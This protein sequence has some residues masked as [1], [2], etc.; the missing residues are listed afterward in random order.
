MGGIGSGRR[1]KA[2]A[3]CPRP[4]HS[5]SRVKL[6]G[7][8]GTAGH[9][10]QR[11]R[12]FPA[13]GD[14]AHVFSGVLPREESWHANCEVC[15]RPVARR[16]G[17]QTA[18]H[19]QFVARGIAGALKA[20]GAGAS[21]MSASRVARERAN[22]MRDAAA[23]SDHG[24]LV[25]DWVEVF[26]P[27]VF[28]AHHPCAWP[29]TGSV[30]LDH[31][32]FRVRALDAAG[33]PIHGGVV[34]FDVFCAMGYDAGRAKLWRLE[35]FADASAASWRAFLGRL[36]GV[37]P[38]VVCDAHDGILAAIDAHWPESELYLCEWHLQHAL[39][40][41]LE[42]Q[43]RRGYAA[44]AAPLLP[45]VE[46]SFSGVHFWRPFAND[47]RAAGIPAPDRWL[48]HNDFLI[49]WQFQ[50]RGLASVRPPDMPLT[51]GGLEQKTRPIRDVLHPRR[52]ALKNRARTNRMLMLMQLHANAQDSEV[53]Y[54]KAILDWLAANAGRPRGSRRSITDPRGTPSLR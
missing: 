52:H 16:D 10:R 11:Y 24:Q 46:R 32:P 23:P 40:R 37:P 48:D 5:G 53:A 17:P 43:S 26:A 44:G 22:R 14:N 7:T 33:R 3:A 29:T 30:V 51:T 15:E 9:R 6:D 27:V 31:L 39:T 20:V 8:Y 13:N 1:S 45:R 36:A 41:L 25:A 38:R 54:R 19:Y 42:N 2:R 50:R 49:Q 4:G 12:C 28:E 18:R 47:C 34:A 21:Y 35:A